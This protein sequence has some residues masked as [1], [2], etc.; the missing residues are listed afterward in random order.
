MNLIYLLIIL[1][2]SSEIIESNL[3]QLLP[4]RKGPFILNDLKLESEWQ[5]DMKWQRLKNKISRH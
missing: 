2:A 1:T 5:G 3:K 4:W